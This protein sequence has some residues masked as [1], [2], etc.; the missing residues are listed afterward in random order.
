[1][2]EKMV[3]L[4]GVYG[5]RYTARQK[6]RFINYLMQQLDRLGYETCLDV[7]R[8]GTGR[9]CK[10]LYVGDLKRA[11]VVVTVPYD[12]PSHFLFPGYIYR[13][14]DNKR[15]LHSEML[16][17]ALQSAA[18]VC[19][20]ILYYFFIFQRCLENGKT[21]SL[22]WGILGLVLLAVG[23]YRIAAGTA[24]P[25]NFDRNTGGIAILLEVMRSMGKRKQIAYAFLDQA[26]CSKEGYVQLLKELGKRA[27]TT[28]VLILECVSAG[29]RLHFITGNQEVEEQEGVEMHCGKPNLFPCEAL[30]AGGDW[31]GGELCIRNTRT[32]RDS[33]MNES[34]MED[35]VAF[36]RRYLEKL[37]R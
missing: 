30:L 6:N 33:E 36:L 13:P 10:N 19:I 18:A 12:T 14:L 31:C 27:E 4:G 9:I 5:K 32:K 15:T 35:T 24:N 8:G 17:Q 21:G 11:G 2:R 1:M 28:H 7:K 37:C 16:Y 26:C 29:E 3:V 20:L 25:Y 22:V 34:K 23:T